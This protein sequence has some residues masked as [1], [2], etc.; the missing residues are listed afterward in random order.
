VEAVVDKEDLEVVV[1]LG[2]VVV[3]DVGRTNSVVYLS[4]GTSRCEMSK[5]TTIIAL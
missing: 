3:L 2:A 4:A 5:L 1:D